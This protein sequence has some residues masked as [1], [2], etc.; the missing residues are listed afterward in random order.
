MPR[1]QGPPSGQFGVS[2][3]AVHARP[4]ADYQR[5]HDWLITTEE[6]SFFTGRHFEHTWHAIFGRPVTELVWSTD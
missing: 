3:A 4:K 5:L 1:V 2:R 6:D